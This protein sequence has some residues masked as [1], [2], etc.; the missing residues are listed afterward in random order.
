MLAGQCG[1]LPE[2]LLP[3]GSEGDLD[4]GL[5]GMS[6]VLEGEYCVTFPLSKPL[7]KK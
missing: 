1:Y 5:L 3:E 7:H 6:L 2:L 4:K